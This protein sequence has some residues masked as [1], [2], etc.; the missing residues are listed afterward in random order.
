MPPIRPRLP[1]PYWKSP[2]GN[3]VL[4]HGDCLKI[5]PLLG[6]V[7]GVITSP[8]YAEQ[9]VGMYASVSEK[10]YPMWSSKWVNSVQLCHQ[11][12]ILINIKEHRDDKGMS[13]YVH[14]TRL[15]IRETYLEVDE[16][17]WYKPDSIPSG[18]NEL[19]RRSWERVLWFSKSPI[20]FCNA[21]D[22]SR[23]LSKF[24]KGL[25]NYAEK[26]TGKASGNERN[27]VNPRIANLFVIPSG[28]GEIVDH[29]A[30]YPTELAVRMVDLVSSTNHLIV[31]PF[32]GSGTTGAVAIGLRRQFTGI[33]IEEKYCKIA[34]ERMQKEWDRM[35]RL[36]LAEEAHKGRSEN[37][38]FQ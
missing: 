13:D 16:I 3:H 20:P 22:F 37:S 35:E 6:K 15:S 19:P 5:L 2:C 18:P 25:R 30:R 12:S 24:N 11:G 9:R 8:P 23:K 28:A 31:D 36:R 26:S 27:P 33:E 4:Y 1:E 17:I 21:K 29:P 34:A 32:T 7:D 10:D 38:L 14:R